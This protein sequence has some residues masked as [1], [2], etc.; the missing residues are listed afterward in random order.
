MVGKLL[1]AS[2]LG[3]FDLSTALLMMNWSF[4]LLT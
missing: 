1:I 2:V 4:D 3:D